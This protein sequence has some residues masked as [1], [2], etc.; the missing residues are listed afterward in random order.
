MIKGL[1]YKAIGNF[2]KVVLQE[3]PHG[4]IGGG[5][6]NLN[7]F[8]NSVASIDRLLDTGRCPGFRYDL[9]WSDNNHTYDASFREKVR[10]SCKLIRPVIDG[11]KSLK[12]WANPVT[13]HKLNEANWS[14]FADIVLQELG[15]SVELVNVPL[16]GSGF[17]SNKYLNEYHGADKKPRG[18]RYCFSADGTS[19]HDLIIADLLSNYSN[20]EYLMS[21]IPQFNGN[22]K[23]GDSEPRPNRI[24]W[25]VA[26]Q[27]DHAIYVLT[28][29]AGIVKI[30]NNTIGKSSGD[31][32]K[33]HATPQGKDCKPVFLA[34][35]AAK[36]AP[37]RLAIKAKNGQTVATSL[38]RMSWDDERTRKQNGWRWYFNEWGMDIAEKA[39]RIQGHGACDLL[40]DG[41]KIGVW[42]PAFRLGSSR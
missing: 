1:D 14:V 15:N 30:P 38:P 17:V 24:Y 39:I 42:N 8:K 40:G 7:G 19:I 22:R 28:H 11:H 31:Q 20:A 12:H 23:V 26:K 27:I 3:H 5:F 6:V 18:G 36:I 41:K 29:R 33:G 13:E 35:L 21:W 4:W 37:S 10:K 32:A 16:H 9:T 25:P 34:Y 2:E